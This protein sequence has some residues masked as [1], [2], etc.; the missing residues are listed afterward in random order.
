MLPEKFPL[1]VIMIHQHVPMSK[2]SS[3][4][5]EQ[6]SSETVCI[7]TDTVKIQIH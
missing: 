7:N 1:C 6:I 2:G 3:R 4:Q 5:E